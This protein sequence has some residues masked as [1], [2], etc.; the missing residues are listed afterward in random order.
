MIIN[1][2]LL[3]VL[4]SLEATVG[5]PVF[6]IYLAHKLISRRRTQELVFGLFIM[7]FFLAIFYSLSWPLMVLLLFIFHL[8]WEKLPANKFFGKLFSFVLLNLAIFILGRLQLNYFYLIHV[9]LFVLYFYKAN[10]KHYAL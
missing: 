1:V 6:F 9:L 3:S 5:L 10:F 4:L 8:V 7:A 2:L